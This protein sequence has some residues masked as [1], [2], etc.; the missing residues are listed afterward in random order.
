[1]EENSLL[2][3]KKM[4]AWCDEKNRGNGKKLVQWLQITPEDD[5]DL[6]IG[7]HP[8]NGTLMGPEIR[9]GKRYQVVYSSPIRLPFNLPKEGAVVFHVVGIK[10][11]LVDL[12][13]LSEVEC[14]IC[15]PDDYSIKHD[16][17]ADRSIFRFFIGDKL[18]A[19]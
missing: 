18:E 8:D 14:V 12:F 11:T 2:E 15:K 1:M 10:G 17:R 5:P 7:I 3:A 9:V 4:V 16:V 6:Y 19:L 13:Q